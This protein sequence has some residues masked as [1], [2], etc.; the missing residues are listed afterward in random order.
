[1]HAAFE[2]AVRAAGGTLVA[3]EDAEGL[4]WADPARA[5]DLPAVLARAPGALWVQLPYAGIEPFLE[6]LDAGRVWTCGKGVYARPVA[7][8]ALALALAGMRGLGTYARATS[9][10]AP[11][12]RNLLDARVTIIGGGGISDEL[13]GLL[14][15]FRCHVTVVRNRPR[16]TPGAAVV[17]PAGTLDAVASADLVVLA[18]ALTP[19]TTGLVDASFLAAMQ[20]HAWLVNVAR[21]AHV[22]TPDL[23]AALQEGAIG[24]AALDVT[25]PEPLPEGHPLFSCASCI[26]TPHVANTPEMGLP[27]IAARVRENVERFGSGSPL[28]GI[29]DVRLGY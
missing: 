5:A 3:P 23:V 20:P 27:L 28:E 21:G 15:P 17:G 2:Q 29:V 4:V 24:G 9:W 12:G 14:A 10:S 7:E 8:H 18:L 11:L 6:H 22:V 19:A 16:P 26:V 25:D 1:M 13:R